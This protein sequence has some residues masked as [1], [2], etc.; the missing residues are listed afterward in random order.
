MADLKRI[1]PKFVNDGPIFENVMKGDDVDVTV[2][3]T[4]KWHEDDGGRYGET[5]EA[6][7]RSR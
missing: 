4:P 5:G 7:R 3:P 6:R 1:E 2:F